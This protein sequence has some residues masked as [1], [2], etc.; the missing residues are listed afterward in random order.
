MKKIIFKFFVFLVAASLTCGCSQDPYDWSEGESYIKLVNYEV[1]SITATAVRIDASFSS[2][3]FYAGTLVCR[4]T[5]LSDQQSKTYSHQFKENGEGYVYLTDLLPNTTYLIEV[6]D[7]RYYSLEYDKKINKVFSVEVTTAPLEAYV[8]EP[9]DLIVTTT[10]YSSDILARF[11]YEPNEKYSEIKSAGIFYGTSKDVT[12][13]TGTKVNGAIE[14]EVI[15][16][17]YAALS[18]GTDYY[19]GA[20]I[21]TA[22]GVRVSSLTEVST[23]K[24]PITAKL[25]AMQRA[26]NNGSYGFTLS[27]TLSGVPDD[28]N[29]TQVEVCGA[30]QSHVDLTGNAE[31]R[32]TVEGVPQGNQ[33]LL[34]DYSRTLF[35]LFYVNYV[36]TRV[37]WPVVYWTDENGK[38]HVKE[39]RMGWSC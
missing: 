17:D 9:L 5:N 8:P 24:F 26:S 21:S 23:G 14:G 11:R 22:D 1:T 38:S 34:F 20:Y 13:E 36:D 7:E 16:V 39:L 25:N 30:R 35:V 33:E 19:V 28:M 4:V 27:F 31:R 32:Y 6:T 12:Y 2:G 29:L 10:K 37:A 15:T 3:S 18:E